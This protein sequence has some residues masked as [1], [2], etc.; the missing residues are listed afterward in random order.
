MKV[1][2][3]K[4]QACG[5]CLQ[6]IANGE[7]TCLPEA[8]AQAH[9][10]RMSDYYGPGVLRLVCEGSGEESELGIRW[11]SCEVCGDPLAGDRYAVAELG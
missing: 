4:I 5:T 11:A 2:N 10:E 6:F 7:A 9:A 1:V 8:E 3:S